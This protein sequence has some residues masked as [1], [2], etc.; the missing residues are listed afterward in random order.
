MHGFALNVDPDLTMF[1]HIVPCGIRDRGVTSVA[2][3]GVAAVVQN[4][5]Q[6]AGRVVTE[7]STGEADRVVLVGWEERSDPLRG[8]KEF[9]PFDAGASRGLP[10]VAIPR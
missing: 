6:V 5:V 4:T 3:E 7:R 2:A 8:N 9:R 10:T 1:G